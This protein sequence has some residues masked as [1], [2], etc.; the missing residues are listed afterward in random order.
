MTS[1]T[2]V[3]LS[4]VV[5]R[6]YKEYWNFKGRYRIVKGGRASKKSK[7]TA[8]WFITNMMD[9]PEANTL[10]VRKQYNTHRDSTFADLIWAIHQLNVQDE[11]TWK[12]S[13]FE[14]RYKRTG[15][16]ILFR[17]LDN[18]QNLTSITVSKG[19]LCWCWFEEAYQIMNEDDFDK[20]DM[21]I[22]GE[23]GGLFK[24]LTLT[25]NPWNEKHWLKR[26]FFDVN[27]PSTLAITTNYLCNEF[28]GD[29]DM[30]LFDWMKENRPRRYKIEGLGDW[31]IAEGAIFEDWRVEEFDWHEIAKRKNAVGCYGLDFGYSVDPTAFIAMVAD[32]DSKEL[33]IFDEH[34]EKGMTNDEIAQMIQ[35]KGY[36]KEPIIADSAEP[37]SI[38]EIRRH[39]VRNIRGAEK[40]K[41]SI[42]NGIQ[43]LQ[44]Y[45]IIVHPSCENTTVE[46]SNYVWKV[47]KDGTTL[48]QPIDDFN[49]LMDAAR[50]GTERLKSNVTK[51]APVPVGVVG[52]YWRK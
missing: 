37:K 46:L 19:Y 28:L 50:Y 23:T 20:V 21:S 38:E 8:L 26:R 47:A 31:G 49:H 10:V 45:T 29:D 6:G 27:N 9:Y 17:G 22:R 35:R 24:Q 11:W 3:K 5:G 13:P 40:G 4:Q 36:A 16:K 12:V 44:Q 43:R 30:Q 33:Y 18:A 2:T 41:D 48:N 1:K 52:S 42:N 14:I 39:G 34:Y 32:P 7:T 25:F 15:Q 51:K